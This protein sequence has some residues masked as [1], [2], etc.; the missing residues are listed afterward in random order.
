VFRLPELRCG[1]A[2]VE[3]LLRAGLLYEVMNSAVF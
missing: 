1:E 3:L 2:L